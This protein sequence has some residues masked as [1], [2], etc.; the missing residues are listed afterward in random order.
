MP[1]QSA[2]LTDL[3]LSGWEE[4]RKALEEVEELRKQGLDARVEVVDGKD[5][6]GLRVTLRSF[7]ELQEY[8]SHR[9]SKMLMTGISSAIPLDDFERL[10]AETST[11]LLDDS[12]SIRGRF[13]E[14]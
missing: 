13:L 10:V 1:K 9:F 12:E 2:D 6:S 11:S 7:K 14:C 3:E 5:P 8:I 4:I